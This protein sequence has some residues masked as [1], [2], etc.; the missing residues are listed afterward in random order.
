MQVLV[1]SDRV[2]P[3]GYYT[4]TSGDGKFE[5]EITQL[6]SKNFYWCCQKLWETVHSSKCIGGTIPVETLVSIKNKG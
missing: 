1:D 6:D 4:P 2:V 5:E 3:V